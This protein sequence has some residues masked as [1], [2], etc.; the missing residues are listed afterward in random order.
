M[1]FCYC[2]VTIDR[3]RAVPLEDV[4][5]CIGAERDRHDREKWHTAQGV[6]SVTGTKFFNWNQG[7][8]G[9]GAIDL[10]IH[11]GGHDFR[12]AVEW[13]EHR[14]PGSVSSRPE[15]RHLPPPARRLEL[16][17]PNAAKL[18]VIK[19]YLVRERQLA[20]AVVELLVDAGRIYADDRGNAVFVMLG[21]GHRPVGAEIRGTTARPFKGL[22]SG[23]RKDLGY[24]SVSVT[25]A[26]TIVLCESAID[27]V[28]CFLLHPE[29]LCISTAGARPDPP[30]LAPLLSSA[31]QVCCGFDADRTGD[32]MARAMIEVH[33]R[34]RRL[35]PQLADWNEVLRDRS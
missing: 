2:R 25:D 22:A 18:S 5:D 31:E 35:R 30:W 28:S 12:A 8:G 19:R 15:D 3:V 29:Y 4:L 21:K 17:P 7:T 11:L 34:V 33:P 9:G 32:D 24:F 10:V 6:L 16:P 23:S 26:E 13:L 27:A 20:G 14:F 1:S